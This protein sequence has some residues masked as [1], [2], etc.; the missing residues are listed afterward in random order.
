[1]ASKIAGRIVEVAIECFSRSGFSGAT[2]KEIS[3]KADVT[4]G[5]LFR[6]FQ[7]KEKLFAAALQTSF[8]TGR[9]PPEQLV[10]MLEGD[11]NFE[12]ALKKSLGVFFDGLD[13]QYVR[14]SAF[15]ILERPELAKGYYVSPSHSVTRAVARVI[16]RE[17]YRGKLREDIDP[18]IAAQQLVSGLWHLALIASILTPE[19]KV[20]NRASRRDAVEKFVDIWFRGMERKSKPKPIARRRK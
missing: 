7:S 6:L 16:E 20:T 12:R 15:G 2:T 11:D 1:M 9:M 13:N 4:E 17:L 19:F 8:E 14:L 18:I 10:D 3:T 5:S